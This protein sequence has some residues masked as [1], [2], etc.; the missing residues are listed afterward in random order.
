MEKVRL[1]II[2]VGGMGTAHLQT[3]GA[4]QVAGLTV[5]AVADTD[6]A[7]LAAAQKVCPGL[8]CFDSA[9]ALLDSGRVDAVLAATPPA[10]GGS[11]KTEA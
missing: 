3:V 11:R 4:G 8:A 6:P 10:R 2:G 7:R 1:G 9:A 5:T